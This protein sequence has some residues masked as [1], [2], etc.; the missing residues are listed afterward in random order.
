MQTS[1]GARS[2]FLNAGYRERS[3]TW[4]LKPASWTLHWSA[5]AIPFARASGDRRFR[6]TRLRSN[7]FGRQS[8]KVA[9]HP[10][11]VRAKGG[12]TGRRGRTR[13]QRGHADNQGKHGGTS[14]PS[15]RSGR[16]IE[17]NLLI[18][19]KS[20]RD[21]SGQRNRELSLRSRET[22]DRNSALALPVG[23]SP[24]LGTSCLLLP[25]AGKA[26]PC[27]WRQEHPQSALC[28]HAWDEAHPRPAHPQKRGALAL[29]ADTSAA[30]TGVPVLPC[31][32]LRA[33]DWD[34]SSPASS[35]SR[36]SSACPCA[37][38]YWRLSARPA[39]HRR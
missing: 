18:F 3:T 6:R 10:K 33:G 35:P 26:I 4:P 21:S 29:I 20:W 7:G 17:A 9:C 31:R 14:P 32:R 12:G 5:F 15:A 2:C 27:S 23:S 22:P 19:Q 13:L 11:P 37:D 16:R 25:E 1:F 34:R 30:R 8:T 36:S 38:S 39:F 28:C 24:F